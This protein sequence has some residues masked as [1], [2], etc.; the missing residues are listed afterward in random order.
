VYTQGKRP[1]APG[2][3]PKIDVERAI[4]PCRRP[5]RRIE[6]QHVGLIALDEVDRPE[7]HRKGTQLSELR[8]IGA[9]LAG[10]RSAIAQLHAPASA[11]APIATQGHARPAIIRSSRLL[12]QQ[13]GS[14][15]SVS[16]IASQSSKRGSWPSL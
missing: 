2:R 12:T 8:R 7:P 5:A 10:R 9:E 14:S 1:V 4:P 3:I 16:I 11:S 6:R 13:P 15:A